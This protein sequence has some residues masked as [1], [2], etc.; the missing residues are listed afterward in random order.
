MSHKD[1]A[2]IEPFAAIIL[3]GVLPRNANPQLSEESLSKLSEL[4]AVPAALS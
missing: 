3:T 1:P 4:V 2:L